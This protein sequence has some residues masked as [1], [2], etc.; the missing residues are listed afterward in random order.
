[1]LIEM[2]RARLLKLPLSR[3]YAPR[4]KF[5]GPDPLRSGEPTAVKERAR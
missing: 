2:V 5:A 3:D 4:W 1:M